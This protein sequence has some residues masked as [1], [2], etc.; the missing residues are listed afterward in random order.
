VQ[1]KRVTQLMRRSG[2]DGDMTSIKTRR[3]KGRI[4]RRLNLKVE[5]CGFAEKF[6]TG[7]SRCALSLHRPCSK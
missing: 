2:I 4:D 6:A 3:K 7:N 1:R 5:G